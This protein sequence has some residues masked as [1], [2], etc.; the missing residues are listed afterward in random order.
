VVFLTDGHL[1]LLFVCLL[2]VVCCLTGQCEKCKDEGLSI[3]CSHCD[4]YFCDACIE[5]CEGCNKSFCS[6]CTTSKYV[7]ATSWLSCIFLWLCTFRFHLVVVC[8]TCSYDA[9]ET[10]IFCLDCDMTS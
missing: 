10:R 5:K 9:S 6:V 4:R 2:F 8:A 1:D 7:R 3:K